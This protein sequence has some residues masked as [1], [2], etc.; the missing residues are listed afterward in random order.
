MIA[1]RWAQCRGSITRRWRAMRASAPRYWR[2]RRECD[3]ALRPEVQSVLPQ[4]PINLLTDPIAMEVLLE[5]LST[6]VR[7]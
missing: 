6:P 1:D 7:N 3:Q 5:P 2:A 4:S